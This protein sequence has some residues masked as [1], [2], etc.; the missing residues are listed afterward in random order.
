MSSGEAREALARKG[1]GRL[2]VGASAAP[3][4]EAGEAT[5]VSRTMATGLPVKRAET[6]SGSALQ[7]EAT[8]MRRPLKNLRLNVCGTRNLSLLGKHDRKGGGKGTAKPQQGKG[9][10]EAAGSNALLEALSSKL[11]DKRKESKSKRRF[12]QKGET[13]EAGGGEHD[14]DRGVPAPA[15]GRD[16]DE[17]GVLHMH[18]ISC[19]ASD[20]GASS[21]SN[22]CLE[23]D[24][25]DD[26][27][28]GLSDVDLAPSPLPKPARAD[29][30]IKKLNMAFATNLQS[31]EAVT[32]SRNLM[33]PIR[34]G[35]SRPPRISTAGPLDL[36]GPA[37]LGALR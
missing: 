15:A 2:Q 28:S 36:G 25:D 9:N 6:V 22:N 11:A 29:L 31:R 1:R 12:R 30:G 20:E 32:L 37:L 14:N 23:D 33:T 18:T 17:A 5:T 10:T 35:K 21:G 27:D 7:T 3:R 34:K 19:W 16:D 4:R 8:L 26:D 13:T 24:D